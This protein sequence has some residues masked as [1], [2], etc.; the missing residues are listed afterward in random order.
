[1]RE[2]LKYL[3]QLAGISTL[4]IRVLVTKRELFEDAIESFAEF[5]IKVYAADLGIDITKNCAAI[6]SRVV[7][8]GSI[9][10]TG[11]YGM[12]REEAEAIVARDI[13]LEA[14]KADVSNRFVF[15]NERPVL[16]DVPEGDLWYEIVRR[17]KN[18][19][20]SAKQVL[21]APTIIVNDSALAGIK[22]VLHNIMS[23]GCGIVIP[24]SVFEQLEDP[25]KIGILESRLKWLY[26]FE[27][28]DLA[29][30]IADAVD[31]YPIEEMREALGLPTMRE[32]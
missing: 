7:E 9:K 10:L 16:K 28:S 13:W 32:Q 11:D 17:Y 29:L 23:C 15:E 30:D 6:I 18:C 26:G 20:P 5:F 31:S 22:A 12:S 14:V 2:E 24:R 19:P 4:K 25:L 3:L 27:D 8:D 1:M 21:S